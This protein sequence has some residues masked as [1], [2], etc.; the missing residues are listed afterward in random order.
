LTAQTAADYLRATGR[1]SADG[2]LL[3]QPVTT[4]T[5]GAA[6]LF[7][8]LDTAGGD[9]VGSDLRT[10]AQIDLGAP[11]TRPHTGACW[12]LKA[13]ATPD[14]L[15]AERDAL[16]L[17]ASLL[18]EGSVS[19]V[20]WV[21]QAAQ[22][23]GLSCAPPDAV[24]W[25]RHLAAGHASVDAATHAGM[26]LAML[27]SSTE[28]DPAVRDRF[29]SRP[30]ALP[31]TPL[32]GDA[33]DRLAAVRR[34]LATA[35]QC[36]IHGQCFADHILLVPQPDVPAAPPP[37]PASPFPLSHL[38]LLQFERASFGHPAA[39]LAALLASF[40]AAGFAHRN[41]WRPYMLLADNCWQTYRHTAA[42]SLVRA[43]SA[44]AGHALA[45][46]L[47]APGANVPAAADEAVPLQIRRAALGMLEQRDPSLDAA[48]DTIALS[49]DAPA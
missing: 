13:A 28:N 32:P 2:Q 6:P 34:T 14:D 49:F 21:D 18:P 17:L 10:P 16:A 7:K 9:R 22:L 1:A 3:V 20:Q 4:G 38:Q 5:D 8:V 39:D 36:L 11:D 46:C 40:L 30:L 33:G 24:V 29:G 45:A 42:P 23:L 19:Q 44:V 47:L 27:H 15:L 26:L 48:L 37:G 25:A 31:H 41:H 35:R 12:M 43:A